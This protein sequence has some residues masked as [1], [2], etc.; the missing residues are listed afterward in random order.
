MQDAVG[1]G[2]DTRAGALAK[3][4]VE[5]RDFGGTGFNKV[6]EDVTSADGW[7]LIDVTHEQEV[8]RARDGA[9][10]GRREL[11]IQHARLVDDDEVRG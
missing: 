7:Q 9:E 5:A 2:N 8:G 10:Q 4:R 3:D 11:S 6:A 1:D